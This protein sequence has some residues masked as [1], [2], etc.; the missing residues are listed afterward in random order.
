[1]ERRS[2]TNVESW[3]GFCQPM[4]GRFAGLLAYILTYAFEEILSELHG[5][6][7]LIQD[8]HKRT[9]HFQNDTENK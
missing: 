5:S 7:N 6:I 8:E 1:M 3:T 9:L 4:S 2:E